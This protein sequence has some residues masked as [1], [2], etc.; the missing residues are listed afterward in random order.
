[1][2]TTTCI[3]LWAED[4]DTGETIC[5]PELIPTTGDAEQNALWAMMRHPGYAFSGWDYE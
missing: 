1:M 2:S 5:I 4:T 3:V